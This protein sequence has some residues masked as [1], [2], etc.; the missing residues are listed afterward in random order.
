MTVTCIILRQK[1]STRVIDL[2]MSRLKN[3]QQSCPDLK[4]NVLPLILRCFLLMISRKKILLLALLFSHF[5]V[6]FWNVNKSHAFQWSRKMQARVTYEIVA[7]PGDLIS[8]VEFQV[9][10]HS[11]CRFLVRLEFRHLDQNEIFGGKPLNY[12]F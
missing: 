2:R 11:V 1:S 4:S 6:Y 8:D 7:K 3:S 12:F 10:Y 9:L 5:F